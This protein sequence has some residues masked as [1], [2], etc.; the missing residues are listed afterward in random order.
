MY[1]PQNIIPVTKSMR[2]RKLWDM[3]NIAEKVLTDGTL[4]ERSEVGQTLVRYRWGDNI[5]AD[6]NVLVLEG[7]DYNHCCSG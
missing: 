7:V 5:K 4:I 6:R 2:M 3:S 1:P